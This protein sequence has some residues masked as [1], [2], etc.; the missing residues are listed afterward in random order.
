ME[1]LSESRV[2]SYPYPDGSPQKPSGKHR[3]VLATLVFQTARA[4]VASNWLKIAPHNVD[5]LQHG[6]HELYRGL[7]VAAAASVSPEM[8]RVICSL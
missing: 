1:A 2:W 6:C 3:P 8:T 4:K 5:I 7:F